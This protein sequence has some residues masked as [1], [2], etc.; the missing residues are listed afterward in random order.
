MSNQSTMKVIIKGQE[1]PIQFGFRQM[2]IFED[3]NGRS[4][5]EIKSRRDIFEIYQ[6]A[7]AA[8]CHR[9]GTECTITV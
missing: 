9:M 4:I 8:G 1:W 7:I 3:R 2:I 5:D 6:C